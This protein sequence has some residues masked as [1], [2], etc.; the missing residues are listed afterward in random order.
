MAVKMKRRKVEGAL[1]GKT[2]QKETD[3]GGMAVIRS[4][5]ATTSFLIPMVG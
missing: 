1:K 5:A 2:I 3:G 4:D